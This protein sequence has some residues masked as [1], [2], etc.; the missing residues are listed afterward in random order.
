MPGQGSWL[1]ENDRVLSGDYLMTVGLN[2]FSGNKL[3][4]HVVEI[5]A[6]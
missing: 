4:S 3:S 6:E 1:S 5:T 2:L